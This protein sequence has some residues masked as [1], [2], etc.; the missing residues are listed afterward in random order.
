MSENL[1]ER[2]EQIRQMYLEGYSIVDVADK[3][4]LTRARIQQIIAKRIKKRHRGALRRAAYK[5]Q[6]SEANKRI[7]AGESTFAVEA[8]GMGIRPNS[9]RNS[10]KRH[11]L[12]VPTRKVKEHGTLY[13]YRLGCKCTE[14]HKAYR[15]SVE[16]RYRKEPPKHGTLNAYTNYACRCD[17]CKRA[18]AAANRRYHLA[19][20]EREVTAA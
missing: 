12:K 7:L 10:M 3:F 6:L 17:A 19:R 20:R 9:L 8:S 16:A 14:C 5:A 1:R 18:G 13:R 2:N 4:E 15:R 11:G